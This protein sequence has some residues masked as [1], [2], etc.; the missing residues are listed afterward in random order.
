VIGSIHQ[1]NFLPWVPYFVKIAVADLHIH[2]DHVEY[3]KNGWTNRCSVSLDSEKHTYITMPVV[4]KDSSLPIHRVRISQNWK[5]VFRKTK[6]TLHHKWSKRDGFKNVLNILENV[7]ALC[8][9]T[10]S[11]CSV[12][13]K[14]VDQ[15]CSF[16]GTNTKT[17]K[18][19][20]IL[21]LGEKS[22]EE[23]IRYLCD[24]LNIT[25][26]ISGSGAANYMSSESLEEYNYR[27]IGLAEIDLDP[28]KSGILDFISIYGD[29]TPEQ[30][31]SICK[32]YQKE[33]LL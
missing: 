19:S 21:N 2:L 18:S 33:Y 22:G 14:L 1:P 11:L 30:F 28:G 23:L 13:I 24:S 3:S 31:H 7:E 32:D 4:K 6:T 5:S 16:L 10:E 26:Y 17:I 9:E 12:N 15:I 27:P 20:D 29:D 25:K 8:L